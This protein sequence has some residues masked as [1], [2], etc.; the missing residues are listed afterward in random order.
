MRPRE[1][2]Q[3]AKSQARMRSKVN[4]VCDFGGAGLFKSGHVGVGPNN[5]RAVVTVQLFDSFAWIACDLPKR[6]NPM[7]EYARQN[8]H[9]IVR[10]AGAVGPLVAPTSNDGPNLFRPIKLGYA[11]VAEIVRDPI[12]PRRPSLAR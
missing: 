10:C 7:R 3:V 4:R 6:I 12:Q 11:K 9:S 2:K 5:F 1:P 8:L